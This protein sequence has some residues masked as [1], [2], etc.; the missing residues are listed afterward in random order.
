MSQ[1]YMYTEFRFIVASKGWKVPVNVSVF[2]D[3][4]K[5]SGL[6]MCADEQD[7]F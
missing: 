4:L 6:Y 5:G 3:H 7:G 1:E 2:N